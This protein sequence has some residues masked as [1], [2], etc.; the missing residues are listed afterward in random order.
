MKTETETE[1]IYCTTCNDESV[2]C[3]ACQGV[4]CQWCECEIPECDNCDNIGRIAC[5]VCD[6]A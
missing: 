5:P 3:P 4:T 2:T 1:I 6:G